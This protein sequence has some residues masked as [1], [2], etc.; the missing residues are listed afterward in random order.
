MSSVSVVRRCLASARTSVQLRRTLAK[1]KRDPSARYFTY[2][3]LLRDG[4]V[5]VGST[6]NVYVRLLDHYLMTSSSSVWVREHGPVQRVLEIVE[7]STADDE[8]YKTLEYMSTFGWERVRGAGWCRSQMRAAPA[9]LDA[10]A[11]DRAD[12]AYMSR[13]RISDV[14]TEVTRLAA[15]LRADDTDTDTDSDD[16]ARC[17]AETTATA[18]APAPATVTAPAPTVTAEP[19]ATRTR[20]VR[21]H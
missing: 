19:S 17:S 18:P 5:Y 6:D 15:T 20:F 2:T 21:T 16:E 3:L 11:R 1:R 12:F 10:F 4:N 7:D 14:V 9:A 13:P 8:K